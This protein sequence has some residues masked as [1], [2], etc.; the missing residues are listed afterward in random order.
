MVGVAVIAIVLA[1]GL[2]SFGPLRDLIPSSRPAPSQLD[3]FSG[4]GWSI[5]VPKG[6]GLV[7][8]ES[9]EGV[10]WTSDAPSD[11]FLSVFR[12]SNLLSVEQDVRGV[13][14][15]FSYAMSQ[16]GIDIAGE[17]VEVPTSIGTIL[18]GGGDAEGNGCAANECQTVI[19]AIYRGGVGYLIVMLGEVAHSE[20]AILDSFSVP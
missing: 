17:P 11:A 5:G 2:V 20:A 14:D 3:Q 10:T 12:V 19:Y 9:G 6:L 15:R 7:G 8:R 1:G 13:W 4:P 18:R 16:Q